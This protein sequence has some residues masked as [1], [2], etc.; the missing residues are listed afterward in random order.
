MKILSLHTDYIKFKPLKKALKNVSALSPEEKEEKTV[1][2]ALA[3]MTAVEKHDTNKEG[4]VA[5]FIEAVKEI[6]EQVQADTVVLYPY[7]HLSSELASP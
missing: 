7:A 4:I 6:A 5:K 3:V 2:N 1:E